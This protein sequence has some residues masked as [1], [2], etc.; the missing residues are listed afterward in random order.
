MNERE[1]LFYARYRNEDGEIVSVPLDQ[2]EIVRDGLVIARFRQNGYAYI[3]DD[4]VTDLGR[5]E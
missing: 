3:P 4:D 1:S 2:I 5:A